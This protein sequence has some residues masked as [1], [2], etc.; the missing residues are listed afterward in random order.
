MD[1]INQFE[2]V[3]VSLPAYQLEQ[4]SSAN[5]F[6]AP[7]FKSYAKNRSGDLLYSLKEGWQPFYKFKKV[8]YTDQTHIPLVFYG[9]GI[10]PQKIVR[11][12]NATDLAP[13]LSMLLQIPAPDKSQGQIIEELIK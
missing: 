11:K 6:L 9:A 4:G 3:Q 10:Q 12:Y 2:A 5:G 8:N 1:F 7:L 13:T